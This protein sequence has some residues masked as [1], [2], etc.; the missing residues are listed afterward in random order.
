MEENTVNEMI[1]ATGIS[2][3]QNNQLNVVFSVYALLT[4]ETLRFPFKM[5][6][7]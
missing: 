2:L 3:N 1:Y 6:L 7:L 5:K 4:G